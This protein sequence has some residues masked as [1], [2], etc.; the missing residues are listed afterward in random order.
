MDFLNP[1]LLWATAGVAVPIIVHLLNRFRFQQIDW[2]AMELLRRA[3]VARSRRVRVEDLILLLLRC[4]A[5]ALVALAFARPALMPKDGAAG[6]DVGIVIAVDASYSMSHAPGLRTRFEAARERTR[7]VLATIETGTPASVFLAAQRPRSLLRGVGYDQA[8]FD[9]RLDEVGPTAERLDLEATI[10]EL[11]SLARELDAPTKEC[12]IVTDAQA[13]DWERLSSKARAAL[14]SLRSV[15]RVFVVPI[16]TSGAENTSVRR[17][18][19]ASGALRKG[20]TARYDV[21]VANGGRNARERIGVRLEVDG[22]AVAER[23][24]ERLEPGESE[25]V[26]LWTSFLEAGDIEMTASIDGDELSVD[27]ERRVVASVRDRLRVLCVD[28]DP[29]PDPYDGET[30]YL[31][32]ALS[33]QP[34]ETRDA[35]FV[36]AVTLSELAQQRLSD[37]DLVVLANVGDVDASQAL[38]LYHSVRD[39]GGLVVFTGDNV[40]GGLLGERLQH[41]G[42]ALL[43]GAIGTIVEANSTGANGAEGAQSL[44][45][46]IAAVDDG[47]VLASAVESLDPALLDSARVQSYHRVTVAA[48][49]RVVLRLGNGDPFLCE[50]RVGLGAV[51]LAA[52]TAGRRWTDMVTHPVYPILIHQTATYLT[53]RDHETARPV[54]VAATIRLPA[55]AEAG[56]VPCVAPGGDEFELDVTIDDGRPTITFPPVSMP[57]FYRVQYSRE[58]PATHVA[59]NVAAAES[60]TRVLAIDALTRA[61][62]DA[63]VRVVDPD[64]S[65]LAVVEESRVGRELWWELLVAGLVIFAIE[66]LLARRFSRGLSAAGG[67]R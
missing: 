58:E 61:V 42:T 49:A 53:R 52:T 29:A 6:A 35:M 17:F 37:Y 26:P 60:D 63:P 38:V 15:A 10:A 28:G 30:G 7:D 18:G 23:I 24:V 19:L 43:P 22:R 21:E 66:F 8:R 47:H 50:K 46:T 9:E 44:G 51:V 4:V 64:E 41:E 20:A 1:L 3:L 57:G 33:S 27:N 32:A 25:V 39:G 16:G 5:I 55:A 36:H 11:E 2:A 59:F 14:E 13:I 34:D 40:E 12:F 56:R 48:D 65:V 31:V 62:A 67:A 45:W 54:G